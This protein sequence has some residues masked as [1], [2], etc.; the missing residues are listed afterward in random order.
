[1]IRV[2]STIMRTDAKTKRGVAQICIFPIREGAPIFVIRVRGKLL[3][4]TRQINET[5]QYGLKHYTLHNRAF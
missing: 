4:V 5:L 3:F 2:C 1:M